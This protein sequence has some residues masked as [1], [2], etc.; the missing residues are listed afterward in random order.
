[1]K[2]H[3][4]EQQAID[5]RTPEQAELDS[6]TIAVQHPET[7]VVEHIRVRRAG[8]L[9]RRLIQ[10]IIAENREAFEL[11]APYDGPVSDE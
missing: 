5:E 6:M 11:L 8:P 2:P 10:K 7:G 1:M 9:P 3:P 4:K